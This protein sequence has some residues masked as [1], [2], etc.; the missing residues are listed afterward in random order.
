MLKA[1]KF[2]YTVKHLKSKPRPLDLGLEMIMKDTNFHNSSKCCK[3]ITSKAW[4]SHLHLMNIFSKRKRV[5]L[6]NHSLTYTNI[7]QIS[8]LAVRM[9]TVNLTWC[10]PMWVTIPKQGHGLMLP[11]L[12]KGRASILRL[13]RFLGSVHESLDSP[14]NRNSAQSILL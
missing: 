6:V 2:D 7:P 14:T 9:R 4:Y 3:M 8:L 12:S 5:C 1:S 10:C 13:P 11:Q